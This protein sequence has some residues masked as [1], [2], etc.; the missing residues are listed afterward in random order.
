MNQS[1]IEIL[2]GNGGFAN[3]VFKGMIQRSNNWHR[4]ILWGMRTIGS[5]MNKLSS[6]GKGTVIFRTYHISVRPI[7]IPRAVSRLE[8]G[9]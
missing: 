7:R 3:S 2:E 9:Q 4:K 6:Y 1:S 8:A 5:R